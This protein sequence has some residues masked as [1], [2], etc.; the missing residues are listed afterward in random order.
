V[1]HAY[2]I[3]L[4]VSRRL[5]VI[6]GGG[7]VAARKA[8]GLVAAGVAEVRVVAARFGEHEFPSQ[9][10]RVEEGYRPAHLDGAGL[11]FAATDDPQVNAAVVRDAHARGL[12]VC[13][14]DVDDTDNGDFAV[15]AIAREG[16]VIIAVSCSGSPALAARVRDEIRARLDPQWTQLAN[17]MQRLRPIIRDAVADPIRRRAIFRDLAGDDAAA[18]ASDY[19][20]LI[21]WL[22]SRYPELRRT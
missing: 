8:A 21:R 14:A 4:D 18:R 1:Q 2:P 15:P 9:V 6:I 19:D 22:A 17:A 7:A 3:M 12:L 10:R 5:A 13:R 11:V 20:E 16:A